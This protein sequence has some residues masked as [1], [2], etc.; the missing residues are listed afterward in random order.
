MDATANDVTG[1]FDVRGFP[2]LY[3]APRD[4]KDRPVRY[5]VNKSETHLFRCLTTIVK[6]QGGREVNDFIK[7]I[8]K[9]ATN[10]LK[11]WDRDGNPKFD[12]TEL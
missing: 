5:D 12:K 8:A 10:E 7:Y 2:T 3:W 4:K 9:E 11:G 1:P 6:F